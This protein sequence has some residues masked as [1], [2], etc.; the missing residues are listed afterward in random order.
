MCQRQRTTAK[1]HHIVPKLLLRRFAEDDRVW[2]LDRIKKKS[3]RTSI[4]NAACEK[5]FYTVETNSEV[6]EDLVEQEFL[7]PIEGKADLII[8][9]ILDSRRLPKGVDWDLMAC[10]LAIMYVRVHKLRNIINCAWQ[11]G[12]KLLVEQILLD[13]KR[14]KSIMQ[15]VSQQT[16]ID[17]DIKYE[18]ALRAREKVNINVD[19]PRTYYVKE[20]LTSVLLFAQVFSEM[21]PHLEVTDVLC[22][23]EFVIS[24]CPILPIPKSSN[25]SPNWRWY[26]NQ[27]ANLFFPLSSRACFILSYD[28]FPTVQTVKKRHVAFVNHL[29]ACNSHRQIIS[30]Q[31]NFAWL[32]KNGAT[33]TS[34]E[35]LLEFLEQISNEQP[36]KNLDKEFFQKGI[37][38]ML[39]E[40]ETSE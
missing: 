14:W 40:R 16:G 35:E 38:N 20:M 34:H 5:D 28:G 25:P 3:Y 12:S 10:F 19:I 37:S 31:Q 21:T 24:D 4:I 18:E 15:E 29:M 26:R 32:K 27:D 9:N 36:E 7:P 39:K 1:R 8:Q 30:K 23:S 22:E 6:G 13:E 2:V 17:I 11:T 33:S